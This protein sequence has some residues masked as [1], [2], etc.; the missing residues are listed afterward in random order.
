METVFSVL[1]K[2]INADITRYTET[3]ASG[4]ANTYDEY[5]E[6]CG[7]IRG[8]NLALEHINDLAKINDGDIDD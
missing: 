1:A 3:I 6:M 2:D 4:S 5:K 7:V 8:L